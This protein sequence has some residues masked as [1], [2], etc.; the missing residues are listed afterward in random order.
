MHWL[1]KSKSYCRLGESSV[2]F[3][4]PEEANGLQGNSRQGYLEL[5]SQGLRSNSS[6]VVICG[7]VLQ[8]GAWRER[9]CTEHRE[10]PG[11][12]I[13]VS[14][15][16]PKARLHPDILRTHQP[17]RHKGAACMVST[18]SFSS[19]DCL[20]LLPWEKKSE[21]SAFL[22]TLG[23]GGWAHISLLIQGIF[24]SSVIFWWA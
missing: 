11:F 5:L 14:K 17:R 9:R 23:D 16:E 13:C 7:E 12:G 20:F 21:N 4:V 18:R 2:K 8:V 22:S 15:I 10:R 6:A 24:W 19:C 3:E 1:H